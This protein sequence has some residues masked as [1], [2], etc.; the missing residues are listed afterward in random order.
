MLDEGGRRWKGINFNKLSCRISLLGHGR[1]TT[2]SGIKMELKI[3]TLPGHGGEL[4]F[5][6]GEFCEKSCI[7]QLHRLPVGKTSSQCGHLTASESCS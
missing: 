1:K 2:L 7:G 5:G 6:R 4:V 3:V